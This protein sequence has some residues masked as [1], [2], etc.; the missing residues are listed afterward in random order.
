MIF[1]D[2]SA[3]VPLVADEPG[4]AQA[5]DVARADG[6][7]VV[8]WGTVLEMLSAV[9]RREREAS[10]TREHADDARRVI[11]RLSEAWSEI[12]ATDEVRDTAARLLRRHEL[13]AA[14]ALQLGAAL[15][16]ARG[17]PE[18]RGLCTFDERLAEAAHAEGFDLPLGA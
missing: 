5:T 14:D 9:A 15:V 10:M 13:R 11:A 16:W 2:T 8:W 7:V 4:S 1:W 18:G 6:D 17:R 3:L 12:T